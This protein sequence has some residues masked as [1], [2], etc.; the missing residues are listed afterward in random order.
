MDF[1]RAQKKKFATDGWMM[2]FGHAQITI[3]RKRA[4]AAGFTTQN[5][6]LSLVYL[7]LFFMGVPPKP[8]T[9]PADGISCAQAPCQSRR[10]WA[11]SLASLARCAHWRLP[12]EVPL[13]GT[14]TVPRAPR[15]PYAHFTRSL[16]SNRLA[17]LRRSAC[18]VDVRL[19]GAGSAR[20]RIHHLNRSTSSHH[21][22]P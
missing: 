4:R 1:D 21:L 12:G 17:P 22:R 14:R 3:F 7:F 18:G 16:A 9:D 15:L 5:L 19:V 11:C 6:Q 13:R 8:P 10:Q 20:R 2:D